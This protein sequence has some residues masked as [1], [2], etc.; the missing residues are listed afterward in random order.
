MAL[1]ARAGSQQ[2][3]H[4]APEIGAADQRVHVERDENDA[5]EQI[6]ERQGTA[7]GM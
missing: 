1:F 5:G 2:A 7:R 6:G 3:P 4:A